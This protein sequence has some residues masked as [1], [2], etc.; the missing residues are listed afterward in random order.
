MFYLSTIFWIWTFTSQISNETNE[1]YFYE[2]ILKQKETSLLF[3][4]LMAQKR[5]QRR[6]D[7]YSEIQQTLKEF[8]IDLSEKSIKEI[9]TSSYKNLVKQKSVLAGIKYLESKQRKGE[10]GI[11]I[12]YKSLEL[13]DY[14]QSYANISLDDQQLLFS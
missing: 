11:L 14:L 2:Y 1:T 8:E 5:E 7:W 9:K 6:G 13:Q 3:Q 4:F 12:K 10:K